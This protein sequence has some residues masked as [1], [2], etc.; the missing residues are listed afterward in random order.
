MTNKERC[1]KYYLSHKDMFSKYQKEQRIKFPWKFTLVDIKT[2]C[3]NKNST[4]YSF[5]GGRGIKCLITTDEL[6]ELWFRDKAYLL[7]Q[8]SIDRIDNDGNYCIENCRYIEKGLNSA[9]RNKR[10]S[11]KPILQFDLQGNFIKEWAS[12]TDASKALSLN[13]SHIGECAKNYKNI[14]Q[15]GGYIWR[16]K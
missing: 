6:K 11:S 7:K 9:E 2:R 16:Y 4:F 14:K 5:Y 12:A 8:P 3:D 10:I 13:N 15:S 1:K